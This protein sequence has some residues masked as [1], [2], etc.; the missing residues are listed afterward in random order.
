[1]NRWT[2]LTLISALA[3]LVS[4][5][6]IIII[7]PISL[8]VGGDDLLLTDTPSPMPVTATP[9]IREMPTETWLDDTP[10]PE[11]TVQAVPAV[12]V[13]QLPQCVN[14]RAEKS[15]SSRVVECLQ[16]GTRVFV[17]FEDGLWW[18]VCVLDFRSQCMAAR[19]GWIYENLLS[20]E[21]P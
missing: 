18:N 20:Y 8:Q 5:C 15:T 13:N 7:P 12:A 2:F 17:Y 11:G 19:Q 1:M 6:T 21:A 14:L 3:L 9:T 10:T 4:A 16:P